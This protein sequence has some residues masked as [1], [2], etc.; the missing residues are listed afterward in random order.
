VQRFRQPD[1]NPRR[2]TSRT[3]LERRAP[4]ARLPSPQVKARLSLLGQTVQIRLSQPATTLGRGHS[5][6]PVILAYI[7]RYLG[8]I[9]I[10]CMTSSL[11][12]AN[13]SAATS[14]AMP[15]RSVERL[16]ATLDDISD[17]LCADAMPECRQAQLEVQTT[18]Q[19]CLTQSA[20]VKEDHD[21]QDYFVPA[22]RGLTGLRPVPVEVP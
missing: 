2:M 21:S 19:L 9:F 6:H 17:A 12:F 16:R 22:Y 4:W 13:S 1:G 5:R 7:S 11:P 20:G 10:A 3:Q 18:T 15:L 8:R 14:S